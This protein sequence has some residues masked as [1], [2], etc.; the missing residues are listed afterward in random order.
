MWA[1]IAYIAFA[2]FAL[3]LMLSAWGL[4]NN[5]LSFDGKYS[6]WYMKVLGTALFEDGVTMFIKL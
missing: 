5:Y 2:L 3:F 4:F 6:P 1:T